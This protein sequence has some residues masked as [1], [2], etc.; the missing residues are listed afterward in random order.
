MDFGKTA[1]NWQASCIIPARI[2]AIPLDFVRLKYGAFQ[3]VPEICG[4]LAAVG[5]DAPVVPSIWLK[6]RGTIPTSA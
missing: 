6:W 3:T 5:H 1:E 4:I 2:A